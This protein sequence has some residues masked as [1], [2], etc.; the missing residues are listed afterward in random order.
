MLEHFRKSDAELCSDFM[1]WSANTEFTLQVSTYF[2]S[3]FL[4]VINA[5]LSP[6]YASCGV[7]PCSFITVTI[8][9]TSRGFYRCS[10]LSLVVKRGSYQAQGLIVRLLGPPVGNH[11]A[12][13]QVVDGL[14]MRLL[15]RPLGVVRIRWGICRRGWCGCGGGCR[16]LRSRW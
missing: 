10:V 9:S 15:S 11:W 7:N 5:R 2:E 8:S 13:A 3:Y 6:R 16:S 12:R 1:T 4:E 14:F